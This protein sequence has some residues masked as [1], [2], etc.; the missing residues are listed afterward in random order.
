MKIERFEDIE[1]WQPV[2][3][4]KVVRLARELTRNDLQLKLLEGFHEEP[5]IILYNSSAR[6][7]SRVLRIL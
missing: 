7:L 3:S 5:R 2:E 1:A 6:L 4:L